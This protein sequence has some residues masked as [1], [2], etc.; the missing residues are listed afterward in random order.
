MRKPFSISKKFA[1]VFTILAI[2][3][4]AVPASGALAAGSASGSTPPAND[5]LSSVRLEIM[6]ARAQRVYDRQGFL[7]SLT[8]AVISRVQGLIDRATTNGW[9]FSAVQTALN[10]FEAVL[11]AANTA[12]LPGAGIIA[13]HNGFTPEG[14]ITD[15]AT[16]INTINALVQ[17]LQ[18]TRSA[19]NGTGAALKEAIKTFRANHPATQVTPTP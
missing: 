16:A 9:D 6:W 2:G 12:H 8:G 1:L 13:G 5:T 4:A 7:L 19:M 18:N 14:K 11:P 3:L 17:V 10:T 15:R